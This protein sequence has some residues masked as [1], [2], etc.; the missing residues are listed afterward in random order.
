VNTE[1]TGVSEPSVEND[2]FCSHFSRRQ[3]NVGST[4]TTKPTTTTP[5]FISFVKT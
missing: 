1:S 3:S 4:E 2:G 5:T